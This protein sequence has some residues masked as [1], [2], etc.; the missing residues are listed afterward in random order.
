MAMNVRR[1]KEYFQDEGG[2]ITGKFFGQSSFASITIVDE[3]SIVNL[4][5]LIEDEDELKMFAPF[6]CGF[7]T[8]AGTVENLASATPEDTATV[9]GLGGVGPSFYHLRS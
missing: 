6:G 1:K 7:Q 2:S 8:G 4:S 9:T 5:G 3:Q